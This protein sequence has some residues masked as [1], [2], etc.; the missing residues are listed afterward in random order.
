MLEQHSSIHML[1]SHSE[2][3]QVQTHNT[4]FREIVSLTH[5][6]FM[7]KCP[8][9]SISCIQ[10]IMAPNKLSYPTSSSTL[11]NVSMEMSCLTEEVEVG[12]LQRGMSRNEFGL[13]APSSKIGRRMTNF[14][15]LRT[16]QLL[17]GYLY[18]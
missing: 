14:I 10:C 2:L 1:C 15:L 6:V 8:H 13:L 18:N 4:L 17:N 12:C 16:M 9:N 11:W 3:V 5:D 7:S